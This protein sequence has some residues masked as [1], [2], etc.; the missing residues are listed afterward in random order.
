MLQ[1]VNT[2]PVAQRLE[3]GTHNPL[4]PG[5]NPGGPS[6]RFGAQRESRGARWACFFM[7]IFAIALPALLEPIKSLAAV[8][9]AFALSIFPVLRDWDERLW[10]NEMEYARRVEQRDEW[11]QLRD[12]A[13]S[14]ELVWQPG[15][16][17]SSHES[18]K[19]NCRERAIFRDGRLA[20]SA[21]NSGKSGVAVRARTIP[22]GWCRI[23]RPSSVWQ[24]PGMVAA[25]F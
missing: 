21:C 20:R 7:L 12:L 19:G 11:V 8:W 10:P 25:P 22:H 3:Q 2:G 5:S 14:L 6:L 24:C 4:V 13:I 18:P 17:G 16:A 9:V 1:C 15:V 23:P